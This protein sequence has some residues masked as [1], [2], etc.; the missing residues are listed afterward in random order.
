MSNQLEMEKPATTAEILPPATLPPTRRL[1]KHLRV[2]LFVALPLVLFAGL[3]LA[4]ILPRL[5][6][7]K[8]INAAARATEQSIPIVN[9]VQAREAPAGS[10]LQLPGNVEA[11]QVAT[12]SAQTTGYLRR[13]YVDIG[14]RVKAGQLLAEIDTPQVDQELQQ[15]RATLAQSVAALAQMEANRNQA[16]TGMEYARVTFE[17]NQYLV[18]Q[19]VVSDQVRDQA[20]AA[21]DEAQ[22]AVAAAQ[23]N[24]NAAK[25]AI[26]A[27]EANVR[28]LKALQ[29]FQ[30]VVSP[31]AGVITARN[32]EVGSLISPGSSTASASTGTS[33]SRATQ[34]GSGTTPSG[35][36]SAASGGGLFEIARIDKLRIFISVPQSYS[37]GIKPDQTAQI[38]IREFPDKTFTGRVVRTT[39]A[40][41]PASRTLLT[42]VQIQNSDY[43][44][45][46]GMYA[47]VDFGVQTADPPTRIPATALII[48]GDGP[49]VA[50]VTS[51]QKVRYQKVVIG[52]DYGSEVDIVSGVEPGATII[53][54]VSDGLKEGTL[55][56]TVGG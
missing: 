19:H 20:K 29:G 55:V 47:T 18:Q 26:A 39:S 12:I 27:N 10:T 4:G 42:E 15:A 5:E 50:V 22:A 24:I 21:Y 38:S 23:A 17:R 13:W 54:N 53:V 51:D 56:Q 9:V 52:R 37:P 7:Q 14:D 44:L 43:A 41:D 3:L 32:V 28:G 33:S 48:D 30:K 16:V 45:L 6:R 25:A 49:R 2:V 36:D 31:F 8:R 1:N 34:P 11:V 35:T 46:P 40:L